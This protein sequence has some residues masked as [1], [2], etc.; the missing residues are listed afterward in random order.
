V[1][2]R[3]VER[4]GAARRRGSA[5]PPL[6]LGFAAI[7]L[8]VGLLAACL[9]Y[10]LAPMLADFS[11]YG[12]H[13][14]DSETAYRYITVLSLKH[15]EGPWWH[16]WLCGGAPAFGYP[17]GAPNFVS[18]YLPL[19]LLTD[20]RVAFRLELLGQ[21]VLG[22]VGSYFFASVL[23]TSVALRTLLCALFV[24]NGRWALQA[25][26]GHTWHLQYAFMP[27]AFYCFERS[28]APGRWRF[29]LGGGVALALCCYADGIYPLPHTALLLSLYG[30]LRTLFDRSW[31]P[32]RNLAVTAASAC[33]LAAPKLCAV[34]DQMRVMPRF[35]ESTEVIDFSDLLAMLTTE[36]QRYGVHPIRVPAYNWHEWGIYVGTGGLLVLF[37]GVVGASGSRG[38]AYKLLGLLCLFLGFGAFGPHAPWALLH[39]LPLFASQHVPSRFHYPMLLMLGAAFVL[40][41]DQILAPLLAKKP[42]LD[43]VLLVPV[44]LMA[45]DMTRFSRTP[46]EQAF[47]M[48]APE[49]IPRAEQF[50]QRVN[51]PRQYI[52]RDWAQP[53]LLAMFANTGVLACHAVDPSFVTTVIPVGSP[54]YRG[55]AFTEGDGQ[56][57][58]TEWTPNHAVVEV[59]GGHPGELLL[60]DMNYDASWRAGSEPALDARG[61]V[62]TR[63]T[64]GD[65]RVEFR[66]FPR[67]LY[68]SL[69]LALL[70]AL[71]VGS[72]LWR[73]A[74][75]PGWRAALAKFARFFDRKPR[76]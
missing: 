11:T 4:F 27:W 36:H 1:T 19:Y 70:S 59:S 22:L 60:Y 71:I 51:P 76:A 20:L 75:W 16:P 29:A 17:E 47:W 50:E 2:I 13:D 23:T 18:P 14:W 35:I 74:S 10:V 32:L 28:L 58:V 42:W 3:W 43:L 12:F 31:V 39:R 9:L 37:I 8:A 5:D 40:T 72:H 61:L 54:E 68:W 21:A 6:T 45:W 53:V 33:G 15:G 65:E 34:A 46:F 67:T 64:S 57:R 49:T 56:A 30:F 73:P 55:L 44:A 52:V 69:P 25:A 26:V 38:L 48:R 63:L 24:L 66:Y 41:L 7:L 62:A